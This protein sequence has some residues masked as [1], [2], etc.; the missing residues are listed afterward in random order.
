MSGRRLVVTADDFGFTEGINEGIER[1]VA[2]GTVKSTCVMTNMPSWEGI[3]EL[4]RFAPDVSIGIHWTV[5]QGRPVLPADRVCSLVDA[6]GGFWDVRE[7]RR[8]A[9][10]GEVDWEELAAELLSQYELLKDA[11]GKVAYWNVHQNVHIAFGLFRRFVKVATQVGVHAMRSHRRVII[12]GGMMGAGYYIRQPSALPKRIVLAHWTR[13]ARSMGMRMPQG[14][15]VYGGR[16]SRN[17][18]FVAELGSGAWR[19][20]AEL[21]IHPASSSEGLSGRTVLEESRIAECDVWSAEETGRT[22]RR[23]GVELVGFEGV[24]TEGSGLRDVGNC[25]SRGV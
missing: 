1:C 20:I 22:L 14:L 8:R 2:A 6:R 17:A 19:G 15:V 21:G 3:R 16:G 11:V 24:A 13:W 9:R 18:R 7:F 23:C 10:C 12:G 5:T 25:G 4:R